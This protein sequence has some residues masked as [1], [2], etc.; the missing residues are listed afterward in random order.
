[1][2]QITKPNTTNSVNNAVTTPIN[3]KQNQFKRSIQNKFVRPKTIINCKCGNKIKLYNDKDYVRCY[4]CEAKHEKKEGVWKIKQ[5][6]T[7]TMTCKC[8][9]TIKNVQDKKET[10][11]FSCNKFSIRLIDNSW[12]TSPVKVKRDQR[13]ILDVLVE[14]GIQ[15]R[16][17][18]A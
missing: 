2:N 11:C 16:T 10:K 4:K 5:K 7:E 9:N 8:G 13:T 14:K 12:F 6:P 15:I 17:R 3:Q 1:M 18:K